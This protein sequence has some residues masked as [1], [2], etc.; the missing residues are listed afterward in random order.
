MGRGCGG[1]R[2]QENNMGDTEDDDMGT[3]VWG[4]WE[5]SPQEGGADRMSG[6]SNDL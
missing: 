6:V 5:R 3:A 1:Y 2:K 4:L